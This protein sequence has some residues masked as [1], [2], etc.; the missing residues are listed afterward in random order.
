MTTR[1]R[2][3]ATSVLVIGTGGAGLRA[4]IELAEAGVSVLAVGKRRKDDAHTT[5]AAGGINAALATMDPDD[6]W[7]QHAADTIKESYL[8]AHPETVRIVTQ[9]AARGIHDLERYGMTFAREA[10]GRIS[11]RFF[12]AHTYRRTAFT[13]DYTGL[14][15]QRTLVARAAQL[16]IPMLE[17]AYITRLL[18]DDGAVF[19]AYGFD[20]ATGT[21]YLIYADAVIL[22]AG[23]H[24]RIWRRTSSRRDENTGDSFRLAVDAGARLRDPELVQF[25]PSGLL[26]PENAAGTLVSEA[27]RG[28]GGILRNALGERFMDRY[29]PQRM[30]LSTRDRVALA[31]Y[32]EIKEGRGTS[33]GGVW[34]DLS[35][36]PR[37]TIMERL[38]R[39]YQTLLELQMLD[40]TQSPIEIAPTAHYSMGGVWVRPE[41][42]STDVRGLYAIGEA[43][44]GLHGANRLGGNSLIELLVFGRLT[45]QAAAAYS[46]SLTAQRR[47]AE[48]VEQARG[49]ITGLLAADGTENVRA[50]QR[51]L[52]NTMTE[53]AGVVRDERGLRLGLT[54]LEALEKRMEDV[55]VHPDIAGYQ[56]LAHAFDLKAATMA[57]RATLEAALERRESRG[58]HNRS[59]FPQTD[60][61][62]RVNLV[63]SPATGV[64]RES[65]PPVPD[66]IAALMRDVSTQGKLV[67]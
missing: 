40:I 65:I 49:E 14:E 30:E 58:C 55:G 57:A 62:L 1:E 41:D 38:P 21:R 64:T 3:L 35:H 23:G 20:L 43:A 48:A 56:D 36:L 63:W 15:I 67:E 42:H 22:A 39:V 28:E 12:G 51:S 60:P 27:A 32:T 4:A 54:E 26:E 18:V 5:L 17:E 11:Q 47:S 9:G 8:L 44:S 6:S 59:D 37:Q 33:A 10:D 31:S 50:L 2:R 52:R 45:G 34:L 7:Q 61:D 46:D 19:G 66:E 16:Q 24:T 13:G 25:H 29:D 53:H